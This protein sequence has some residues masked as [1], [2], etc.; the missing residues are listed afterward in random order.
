MIGAI[1]KSQI[2]GWVTIPLKLLTLRLVVTHFIAS[3]PGHIASQRLFDPLPRLHD[4]NVRSIGLLFSRIA[5]CGLLEIT[6]D[7]TLWGIQYIA[8]TWAG[9]SLF[10]WGAL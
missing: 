1:C 3:N 5:L 2:V 7:L 10:G 6:I 9:Q 8:V 4:L